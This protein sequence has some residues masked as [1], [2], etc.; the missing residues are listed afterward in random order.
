LFTTKDF[1]FNC[2]C[3]SD[4]GLGAISVLVDSHLA[5]QIR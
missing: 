4:D 2:D 1:A 3:F 5:Q